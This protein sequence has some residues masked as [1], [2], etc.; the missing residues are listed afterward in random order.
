MRLY[1]WDYTINHNENEDEMKKDYIDTTQIDLGLDMD[2][3]MVNIRSVSVWWYLHLLSNTY[4]T[5]EAQ[6]MRR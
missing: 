5:L 3:N 6:F 4:A 1:S 2:T